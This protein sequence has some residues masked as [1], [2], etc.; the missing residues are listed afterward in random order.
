MFCFC[1]T[2]AKLQLPCLAF[3]VSGNIHAKLGGQ[4]SMY[5]VPVFKN[6]FVCVHVCGCGCVRARVCVWPERWHEGGRL[7]EILIKV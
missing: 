7:G 3:H 2:C 5:R 6:V 4:N 1:S